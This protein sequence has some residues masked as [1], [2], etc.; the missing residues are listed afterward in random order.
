[1]QK[2]ITCLVENTRKVHPSGTTEKHLH[3]CPETATS[4]SKDAIAICGQESRQQKLAVLS[5]CEG[6]HYC[7][8]PVKHSNTRQLREP[9]SSISE[10]LLNTVNIRLASYVTQ[11]GKDPVEE[12]QN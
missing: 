7:L 3:Y 6:W 12:H 9:V 8:S 4:N 1:M 11:K 2:F 5:G 10:R